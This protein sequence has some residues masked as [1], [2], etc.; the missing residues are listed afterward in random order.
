MSFFGGLVGGFIGASL[1]SSNTKEIV[2]ETEKESRQ[3]LSTDKLYYFEIPKNKWTDNMRGLANSSDEEH[4]NYE[5]E[6]EENFVYIA[7]RIDNTVDSLNSIRLLKQI[8]SI[9]MRTH[10]V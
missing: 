3:R 6:D 4:L 9:Q 8:Q 2:H 10:N 1:G 5:E 7:I